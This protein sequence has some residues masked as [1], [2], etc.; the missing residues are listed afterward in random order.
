[1]IHD[2][3]FRVR[4]MSDGDVCNGEV[5]PSAPKVRLQAEVRGFSSL[6]LPSEAPL[7]CRVVTKASVAHPPV[8]LTLGSAWSLELF[9]PTEKRQSACRNRPGGFPR[10]PGIMVL[11]AYPVTRR[12]KRLLDGFTG[13]WFLDSVWPP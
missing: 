4:S 8:A 12:S 10:Y 7:G 5:E 6:G 3:F 11:V 2:L 1:M 9:T 13:L